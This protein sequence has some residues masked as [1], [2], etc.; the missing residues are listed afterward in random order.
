M[1]PST[2]G[3]PS[4]PE[5][6][7]RRVND[8]DYLTSE[9]VMHALGIKKASLYTYVSRGLVRTIKQPGQKKANLY[10]KADVDALRTRIG[11]GAGGATISHSLRYGDP[12]GAELDLRHHAG[13]AALPRAPCAGPGEGAQVLRVRGG[14]DLG[15]VATPAGQCVGAGAGRH[16]RRGAWPCR[17]GCAAGP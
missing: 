4:R 7:D 2:A 13:R 14:T 9:E 1:K 5:P 3:S 12:V 6:P 15:R 17:R 8:V 10:L 16:P 11:D